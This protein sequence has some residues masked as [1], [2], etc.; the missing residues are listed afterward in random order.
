MIPAIAGGYL[1]TRQGPEPAGPVHEQ[2]APNEAGRCLAG[3][4][5]A[6][7]GRNHSDWRL[8]PPT[9]A[10]PSP[11]GESLGWS[12]NWYAHRGCASGRGAIDPPGPGPPL[13]ADFGSTRQVVIAP[14]DL[15]KGRAA[16]GKGREPS[17][18]REGR[19]AVDRVAAPP[20]A[21]GIDGEAGDVV[22]GQSRR[23]GREPQRHVGLHGRRRRR[24]RYGSRRG[25]WRRTA[26][27]RQGVVTG[28]S[29]RNHHPNGEVVST[30]PV[31]RE[32]LRHSR[33]GQRWP[34]RPPGPRP[35]PG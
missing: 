8:L 10:R 1:P 20:Q 15:A 6:R 28:A 33:A 11:D 24:S 35:R 17:R 27:A 18:Q 32:S 4:A 26:S 16:V 23:G 19:S 12:C 30:R 21:D 31:A 34:S 29:R 7:D 9:S 22:R 3:F 2:G 5:T 14:T 25:R 13:I